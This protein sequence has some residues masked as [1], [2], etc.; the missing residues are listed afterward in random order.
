[1]TG[2]SNV[3]KMELYRRKSYN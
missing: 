1:V 2:G 3:M